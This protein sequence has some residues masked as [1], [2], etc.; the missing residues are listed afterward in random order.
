MTIFKF[1][2]LT[3]NFYFHFLFMLHMNE[4]SHD[5]RYPSSLRLGRDSGHKIFS[6]DELN[7]AYR[8]I[9][10]IIADTGRPTSIF[11]SGQWLSDLNSALPESR[12]SR[13]IRCLADSESVALVI[14]GPK[15]QAARPRLLCTV[16]ASSG[17]NLPS[18]LCLSARS[19][20]ITAL[21]HNSI[22]M[23]TTAFCICSCLHVRNDI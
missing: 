18:V 19:D 11:D 16:R 4:I 3:Y 6:G 22:T 7:T 17:N 20:K 9:N 15:R 10:N 13:I 14:I 2:L 23:C 1:L 8:N 21:T 12:H 5:Y